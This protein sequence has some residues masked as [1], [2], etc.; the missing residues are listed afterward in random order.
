V[1]GI[2]FHHHLWGDGFRRV[3]ERRTEPPYLRANRLV[4]PRGGTFEVDATAYAPE[5]RLAEL[6]EQGLDRA[7]VSL[8]PTTEPTRDL[9]EVW[10]EDALQ[11]E[12]ASG[13]RLV[14]LAYGEARTGFLGAIVP[15]P[16]LADLDRAAL[17]L[18]QLERRGQLAFIHPAG[19]APTG[20]QWRT[21]GLAYAHQ[22]LQAYAS[23]ITD[24]VVLWPEL[25]VVF[26]LLGG[27]APFQIERFVRRGLDP[28]APF[29][30]NIWFE[31]S[32]YGERALEL[33]LQTF[34]AG[35]F[36]FGS[37]AP[38]DAVGDARAAVRRFG[39]ALEHELVDANPLALLTTERHRWAA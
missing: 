35:R 28:R 17:V 13:G 18:S 32:S 5:A 30:P 21:A 39:D 33:S 31:T 10:H 8:P 29:V 23:W 19:A 12:E 38:I 36:V 26:A 22:M 37:D 34:G 24:G 3:L 1:S 27:G 9:V 16:D 2:D 14:P 11:L 7:V 25:R 4:L 15:A 6:D 20:P